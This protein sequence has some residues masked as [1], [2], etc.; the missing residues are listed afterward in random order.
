MYFPRKK[1]NLVVS[2]MSV[3]NFI[4]NITFSGDLRQNYV[5]FIP[6]WCYVSV[7]NIISLFKL[8]VH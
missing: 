1:F 6:I 5:K 2:V 8:F 3:H 4:Y 7:I